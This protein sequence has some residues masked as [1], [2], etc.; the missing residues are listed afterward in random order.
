MKKCGLRKAYALGG[1]IEQTGDSPLMAGYKDRMAQLEKAGPGASV[2]I[3]GDS[4]D[5]DNAEKSAR[6][7]LQD[8]DKMA[9]VTAGRR[10]SSLQA[11]GVRSMLTN[12]LGEYVRRFGTSNLDQIVGFKNGGKVGVDQ[13]GFI[14]GP[15]GVDNVP[16]RVAET[17]EEIRV[18]AG[19]R[20][21]NK[22]QNEAL[23]ELAEANGVDLDDY[24]ARATGKPVGPTMKKGLRGLNMGGFVDDF[25][26][27]N[28]PNKFQGGNN[29]AV[30]QQQIA[31]AA[32]EAQAAPT[33][34][35][36]RSGFGTLPQQSGAAIDTVKQT[37][38]YAKG[39]RAG[40]A[41]AEKAG[42]LREAAPG[43][44]R[45]NAVP[46]LG[47]ALAAGAEAA[48]K[49]QGDLWWD[50]GAS[51]GQKARQFGRAALRNAGGFAGGTIGAG[52]GSTVGPVGTVAG[53]AAGGVA[54]YKAGD[55]LGEMLL[56]DPIAERK[57]QL[58]AQQPADQAAR[59]PMVTEG[60]IDLPI[61]DSMKAAAK[62]QTAG[63][64][65]M[66]S[67]TP[68]GAE[69]GAVVRGRNIADANG[70]DGAAL[71]EAAKSP[72]RQ[73]DLLGEKDATSM[74]I[75]A[76]AG[77]VTRAPN[78]DGLR[79]TTVT[80][81]P[82]QVDANRDAEFEAKGY[83]K[84][85]F[86]N[87]ITPQRVADAQHLE[88]LQRDRAKFDAFDPSITD[89]G[90]Q[91]AGLRRVMYDT[92]NDQYAAKMANE[93][94]KTQLDLA[95]FGLD[96]DKHK[97]EGRKVDQLQGNN[98][99][100]FK[101]RALADNIKALDALIE[102]HYP[103]AGLKDK[104]LAAAMAQQARARESILAGFGGNVPSDRNQ[105][106]AALFPMLKQ[107]QATSSLRTTL[108]DQGLWDRFVRNSG[109]RP[110]LTN[111]NLDPQ[112]YDKDS[113]MLTMPDGYRVKGK[114]IWGQDA[115]IRDAVLGRITLRNQQR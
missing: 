56:G 51:F 16:A 31:A 78:K 80:L 17:G 94:A 87:W 37:P 103:T 21:V 42:Q 63:L 107:A 66:M 71:V 101:D 111:Q 74:Q 57:A 68:Q 100:D 20:I 89:S 115:D 27:L 35:V 29:R 73:A 2:G 110:A 93:R 99:R 45:A 55:A 58:A 47:L 52:A 10:I 62:R 86:G 84:D 104:E 106:R 39:L 69:A 28:E 76:G 54:G 77:V 34:A 7:Q 109:Q 85:A 64:K 112:S 36:Q 83:G 32:P 40:A 25:G 95:K 12:G 4:T 50:E 6:W 91:Q 15:G 79:K 14:K 97:L 81:G 49:D 105:F 8:L 98:E 9:G 113:D 22:D 90:V 23:E 92:A 67:D 38:A 72:S 59:P 102:N 11:Q 108:Q 24:L 18:G 70:L 41:V 33:G 19:E 1:L 61:T 5:A 26:N 48:N 43:F 114:E 75:P 82:S 96:V 30:L 3:L 44:A 88:K 46:I 13:E 60:K 53:G 65:T